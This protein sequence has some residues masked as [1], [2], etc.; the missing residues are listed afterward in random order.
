MRLTDD[1]KW[2]KDVDV[3]VNVI[4]LSLCVSSVIN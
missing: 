3:S 1:S 4:F 2:A